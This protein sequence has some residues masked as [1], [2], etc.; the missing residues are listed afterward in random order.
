M[1]GKTFEDRIL[2]VIKL[3]NPTTLPRPATAGV[4]QQLGPPCLSRRGQGDARRNTTAGQVNFNTR[5]LTL[6]LSAIGVR[7]GE[8]IMTEEIKNTLK[9]FTGKIQ[10]N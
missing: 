7:L 4:R 10:R 5:E 3:K 8:T 6:L 1:S 9:E 2:G